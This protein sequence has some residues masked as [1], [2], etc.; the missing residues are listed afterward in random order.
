MPTS[1]QQPDKLAP[2]PGLPEASGPWA[3]QRGQSTI[4]IKSRAVCSVSCYYSCGATAKKFKNFAKFERFTKWERFVLCGWWKLTISPG[5]HC[6]LIERARTIIEL[7]KQLLPSACRLASHSNLSRLSNAALRPGA[8]LSRP[9]AAIPARPGR[10][11]T[12]TTL[13]NFS[14]SNLNAIMNV[15]GVGT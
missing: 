9:A 4:Q 15:L 13:R 2:R 5:C 12:R 7:L 10:C 3:G 1:G 11:V 14:H 6:A 8:P